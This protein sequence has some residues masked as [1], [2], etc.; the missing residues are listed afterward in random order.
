[1]RRS[2]LGNHATRREMPHV[3]FAS[4]ELVT[5]TPP[6]LEPLRGDPEEPAHTPFAETVI[7]DLASTA[8]RQRFS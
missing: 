3:V 5:R 4:F 6:V 2:G 7:L 8:S 1:M